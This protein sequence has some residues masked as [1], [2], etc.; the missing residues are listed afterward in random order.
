MQRRDR[1]IREAEH[2]PYATRRKLQD[3]TVCPECGALFRNGRWSRETPPFDA[4]RN[5]CPACQRI[6]DRYPAGEI[7]IEGSFREQHAGEIIGLLRNV[8]ARESSRHPL[9]RIMAIREEADALIVETTDM[10]LARALGEALASAYSGELDY[11]YEEG[12]SFLRV[13][14]KR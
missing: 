5:L 13:G 8:E 6:R 4:P 12:S 9:K 10:K 2:D 7:R 14:W 3:P 11:R 1:L